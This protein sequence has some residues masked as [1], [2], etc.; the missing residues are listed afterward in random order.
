MS[1]IE[2]RMDWGE[3]AFKVIIVGE[4]GTGKSCLALRYVDDQFSENYVVTL[5]V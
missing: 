5:G 3:L 1:F 4:P 2:S